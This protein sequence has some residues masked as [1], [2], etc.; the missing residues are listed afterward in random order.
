MSVFIRT[1]ATGTVAMAGLKYPLKVVQLTMWG[2]SRECD[3][4]GER[5]AFTLNRAG[6]TGEEQ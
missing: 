1:S 6:G 4:K 5:M 3:G 2:G